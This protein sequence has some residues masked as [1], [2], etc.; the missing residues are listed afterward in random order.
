[1][2]AMA[3]IDIRPH[4]KVAGEERS[5]LRQALT[6]LVV[7]QPLT[8]MAHGELC[9]TN[10]AP[11][12]DTGQ[13]DYAFQDVALGDAVEIL[14]QGKHTESLFTGEITALEERYGEG[15][16]Q[17]VLLV[18]DKLHRLTR[19]RNNRAFEDQSF[20][21]IISSVVRDSGLSPDV[22]VSSVTTHCHQ[23][24]E[25][26]LAFVMRLCASLDIAVRLEGESVRARPEE[27]D[28][29]PITLSPRDSIRKLRLIAD[30]NHQP[31]KTKVLGFNPANGEDVSREVSAMSRAAQATTAADTLAQLGWPG[32]E[33][34]PQP[35][36]RSRG[37][38][39]AYAQAA[40]DRAAKR[41]IRGDMTVQGE[42]GL[43]SGREVELEGVSERLR[44]TYQVVH[45]AH[46]YDSQSG[47]ETQLNIVKA[48]WQP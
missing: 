44:G 27:P 16:P 39:E 31:R 8:G 22:Q 47:Y 35:F 25:S 40:Y 38:A 12:G 28:S 1:M 46:R 5:D 42:P 6:S 11:D 18:Q 41:F 43:R 10:W 45:C 48:D 26:D 14:M 9:L 32:D 37:E 30:L 13:V 33:I 2:T 23:Q 29:R 24:N 15:A 4:I 3:F 21:D 20:D 17:L 19:S 34:I 7:N 36:P